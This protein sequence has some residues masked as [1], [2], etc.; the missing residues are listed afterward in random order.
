MSGKYKAK[1]DL[2][3]FVTYTLQSGLVLEQQHWQYSSTCSENLSAD[4]LGK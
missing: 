4:I 2:P 3:Y 1:T